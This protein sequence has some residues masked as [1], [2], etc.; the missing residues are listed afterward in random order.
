MG[1]GKGFK[2][3]NDASFA[4]NNLNW[5]SVGI[6]YATL[7]RHYRKESK[8]ASYRDYLYDKGVVT[9]A[10]TSCQGSSLSATSPSII[11]GYAKKLQTEGSKCIIHLRRIWWL[12]AWPRQCWPLCTGSSWHN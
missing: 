2:T 9:L 3:A 8:Q 10:C 4:N 1:G 12:T 5:K 7:W 11:T 6:C